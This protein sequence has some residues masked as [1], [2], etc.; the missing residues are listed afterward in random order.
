MV[1]EWDNNKFYLLTYNKL[2]K[3]HRFCEAYLILKCIL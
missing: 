3:P 1:V 2:N